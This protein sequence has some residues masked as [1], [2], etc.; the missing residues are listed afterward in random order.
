MKDFLGKDVNIG[1][2][3]VMT[4]SYVQML[5]GEVVKI[6]AKTVRIIAL[7]PVTGLPSGLR[8]TKCMYTKDIVVIE[9]HMMLNK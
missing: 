2:L 7:H 3:V 8:N 4:S 1:D 6:N 9:K 5:L